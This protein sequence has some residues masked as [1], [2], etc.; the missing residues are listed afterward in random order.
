MSLKIY[1][2]L[3]D[4]YLSGLAANISCR[5]IPGILPIALSTMI[6]IEFIHKVK[7][8]LHSHLYISSKY[9]NFPLSFLGF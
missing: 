6:F 8:S 9:S 5:Y 3:V 2:K 4:S 7:T 1:R